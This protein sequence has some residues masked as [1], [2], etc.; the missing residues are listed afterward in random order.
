LKGSWKTLAEERLERLESLKSWRE[1][2]SLAEEDCEMS[3]LRLSIKQ[4]VGVKTR[5]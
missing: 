2:Q 4:E 3:W 5:G 1:V